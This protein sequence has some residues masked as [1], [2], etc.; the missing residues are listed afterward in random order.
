ML[1]EDA[2]SWAGLSGSRERGSDRHWRGSTGAAGPA[3]AAAPPFA[4]LRELLFR[5]GQPAP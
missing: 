5:L 4:G 3:G 1:P 2:G